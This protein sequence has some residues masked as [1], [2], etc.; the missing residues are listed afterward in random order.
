MGR[1]LNVWV[2]EDI[3]KQ[4]PLVGRWI[5]NAGFGES[6]SAG[7]ADVA[8]LASSPVP[9]GPRYLIGTTHNAGADAVR[10]LLNTGFDD[11][12]S[13]PIDEPRLTAALVLAEARCAHRES[14]TA[15]ELRQLLDASPDLITVVSFDGTILWAN[16]THA[17]VLDYSPEEMVGKN[18]LEMIHPEDAARAAMAFS[19]LVADSPIDDTEVRLRRK[20][21]EWVHVEISARLV[22]D[23]QPRMVM[24]S[25]TLGSRMNYVRLLRE[26]EERFRTVVETSP[27]LITILGRD[28]RITFANRAHGRRLGMDPASLIGRNAITLLHPDDRV[29]AAETLRGELALGDQAA[30]H[31]R[32]GHADGRWLRFDVA[33][34][35]FSGPS[36][37]TELVV[38][39]RDE[40][41]REA[42]MAQ[43]ARLS[44]ILAVQQ[45]NSPDGI[46]VVDENQRPI[47]YTSRYL[48]I[49]DIAASVVDAGLAARTAHV[50]S[51]LADPS[52]ANGVVAEMYENPGASA[53][54]EVTL[55]DGRRL[56]TYTAPLIGHD[57]TNYGRVWY[58]R[59]VTDRRLAEEALKASEE[60]YRRLVELSPLTIAVHRAGEL[61]YINDAGARIFGLDP[62]ALV[63]AR[64]FEM[65]HPD[66][67]AAVAAAANTIDSIEGTRFVEARVML[68]GGGLRH[69]ELASGPIT[70]DGLPSTQTVIRD[71]TDRVLA[72][73]AIR[74]T[75]KRY[76]GVVESSPDAI[77]VFVGEEICYANPAAAQLL[78]ADTAESMRGERWSDFVATSPLEVREVRASLAAGRQAFTVDEPRYLLKRKLTTQLEMSFAPTL[79]DGRDAV[80]AVVRD[81]S[82]RRRAEQERLT[83]EQALLETQKLESLGVMAGG[84][85][86]DFNNLLVAIMGNAG[87]ATMELPLDSPAHAYLGEI[88]TASQRAAD[89]ARQMLAY[90]GK[91]QFIVSWI[92]L[93]GLV[94]EMGNLLRASLPGKVQLHYQLSA[95]LPQIQCD[96]TQIRQ[97]VMNLVINAAESISDRDGAITLTTGEVEVR[98]GDYAAPGEVLKPGRHVF[99]DVRDTGTGMDQA[100]QARIFEPFFT[101]KFTGRGLGLAAVMGIAR[102]HAGAIRV[103]SELGAGTTFRLF[104]PARNEPPSLASGTANPAPLTHG[105]ILVIDDEESVRRVAEGM[106]ERLGYEVVACRDGTEALAAV[107]DSPTRFVAVLL[108]MLIP[109]SG[110]SDV[111]RRLRQAGMDCPVALM[112]GYGAKEALESVPHGAVAAF[113]QKPFTMAELKVVIDALP[114]SPVHLSGD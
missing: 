77:V 63:G 61:V 81:I 114:G 98:P 94:K 111:L 109:G 42:A 33:V 43:L 47:S 18:G 50:H 19:Q 1:Q 54:A 108:D 15:L 67:R 28:G 97:I 16:R 80:Q 51:K 83:L 78:G 45:E 41:E 88:E 22:Q 25:R 32:I 39:S 44:A 68:P 76:R 37:S 71:V 79:F 20:D 35:R 10:H 21:G 14:G 74:Q 52:G 17:D 55:L 75:E 89:L 13:E 38:V 87:L 5:T 92:D 84:I 48:Q 69:V 46:L 66:D 60:R 58:Y 104:L 23:G 36:G 113:L 99:L 100:T 4:H 65:L 90:S 110:G 64:V 85:A 102:G 11:T 101:T 7:D 56:D 62:K 91:G 2:S 24:V 40:S 57:G 6:L 8:L 34:G 86:H 96:A 106:L 27:D 73:D 82:E 30:T 26:S 105:R 70:Y 49:W 12:L 31:V 53:S 103:E 95:S 93:G 107:A 9:R 72:Q 112:S 59:D 3:R 29:A